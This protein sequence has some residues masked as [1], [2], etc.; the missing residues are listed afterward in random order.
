[1]FGDARTASRVESAAHVLESW[2]KTKKRER[3]ERGEDA[4]ALA[5]VPR[6]LPA[7]QRAQRIAAKA[8]AAG[9]RWQDA[10]GAL[11]KL[12]EE[13][14]ELRDEL[15]PGVAPPAGEA[16]ERAERE[17][18][19]VLLAAATLGHYTGLD[20]ERALRG[21][22]RRYEGRFREMER[23]LAGSL[24]GVTLERQLEEWRRAKERE[25]PGRP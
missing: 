25:E 7:L 13:L 23:A 17:L 21:A 24:A 8:T 1:V 11:A 5:G 6:S 16:L 14:T 18:G 4:S 22:L 10:R 3:A 2:E 12:E 19:D 9:F 20:P 15:G